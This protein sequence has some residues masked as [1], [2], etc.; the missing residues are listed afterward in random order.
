[1]LNCRYLKILDARSVMEFGDKI[2]CEDKPSKTLDESSVSLERVSAQETEIVVVTPATSG[3]NSVTNVDSLT[4]LVLGVLEKVFETM[5]E[6]TK[7]VNMSKCIKCEGKVRNKRGP[8][9]SILELRSMKRAR[10]Y[11]HVVKIMRVVLAVARTFWFK[12]VFE[13]HERM[14][15]TGDPHCLVPL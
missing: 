15:Y 6:S 13:P 11:H 3:S 4:Q 12:V 8:S 1:M 7:E 5:L 14:P 10:S 9:P 2:N